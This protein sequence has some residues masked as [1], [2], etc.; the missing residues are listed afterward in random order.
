M[1]FYRGNNAQRFPISSDT[2][3]RG[4]INMAACDFEF[5]S[6]SPTALPGRNQGFGHVGREMCMKLC[7]TVDD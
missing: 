2:R 6:V 7:D 1:G 4:R 3:F 5:H